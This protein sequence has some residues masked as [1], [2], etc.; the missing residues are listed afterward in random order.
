VLA[1][2]AIKGAAEM[3]PQLQFWHQWITLQLRHN[4]AR[5]AALSIKNFHFPGLNYVCFDFEPHHTIRLYIVRPES[6]L[7]TADV[8]IHNHLYDSQILVLH[9]GIVNTTY[10]LDNGRDDFN[11]YSLTSALAP[12]NQDRCIKLEFI[13][14]RGLLVERVISLGPGDTHFQPHTEIHSVTNDPACLTAF[15]VFEFPTV[16]KNSRIFTRTDYSD[17][18]PTPN[19]YLRYEAEELRQLVQGLLDD[20]A[21]VGR[22]DNCVFE[23][24]DGDAIFPIGAAA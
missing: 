13:T 22:V 11:I 20:M 4:L 21:R 3:S 6:G 15:M 14:K 19:A 8:N 16:K 7:R 1:R 2:R 23:D 5:M 18:I 24:I 9:G 12:S 17:T 10:V